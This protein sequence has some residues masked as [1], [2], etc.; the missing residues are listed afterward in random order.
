MTRRRWAAALSALS[1]L[2][3]AACEEDFVDRVGVDGTDAFDTYVSIGTSISMGYQSNGVYYAGQINSW[4]SLLADAAFAEFTNPLIEA[5]GC[6]PPIVAPLQFFRRLDASSLAGAPTTPCAPNFEEVA[7]ILPEN[8]VAIAGSTASSALRTSP[9]TFPEATSGRVLYSRVLRADDTQTTAMVAQEPTFVSVE[10]GA[11]EVLGAATS[12]LVVPTTYHPVTHLVDNSTGTFIPADVFAAEYDEVID[13]VE[14]TDARAVL[15][16]VP[17]VANIVS[18][19][20]GAEIAGQSAAFAARGVTVAASCATTDAANLLFVPN[21]V[22]PAL[23]A[24]AQGATPTLSC[25]NVPGAVDYVLSPTEAQTLS[26]NIAAM[27]EH[28]A[29]VA[30]ARGYALFEGNEVLS[31]ITENKPP[32]LVARL[33]S[34][35]YPYGQFISLDGVHPN[36]N[37]HLLIANGA[38]EAINAHYGFAIP[39]R[40]VTIVPAND[41]CN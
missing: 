1:A 9:T 12:G 41:V 15:V 33:L 38:A 22:L 16:T 23:A 31:V 13:A 28:I 24:A 6:P 10:L 29:E 30:G 40:T 36:N 19:R 8:N 11:N 37:G 34:C 21:K 7:T 26:T 25:A 35:A 27:N 32:F 3:L 18:L 2:A 17:Q 5:P 4:P 39:Q 14:S 20:T